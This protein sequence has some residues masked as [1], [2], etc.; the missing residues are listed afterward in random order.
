MG[1]QNM[2]IYIFWTLVVLGNSMGACSVYTLHCILRVLRDFAVHQIPSEDSWP[3][4]NFNGFF[5]RAQRMLKLK[6]S[7]VSSIECIKHLMANPSPRTH[8]HS[9]AKHTLQKNNELFCFVQCFV[10]LHWAFKLNFRRSH[11]SHCKA[12]KC[13]GRFRSQ[14]KD[15][16]GPTWTFCPY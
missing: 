12:S 7:I 13:E 2:N 16:T 11:W 9:L 1:T 5:P 6:A 15:I 10:R 8:T 14:T 4:P 3:H